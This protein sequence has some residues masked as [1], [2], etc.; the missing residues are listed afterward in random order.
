MILN[1][2]SRL[3]ASQKYIDIFQL[4]MWDNIFCESSIPAELRAVI[5]AVSGKGAFSRCNGRER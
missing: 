2:Q 5:I 4:S 3:D 1:E